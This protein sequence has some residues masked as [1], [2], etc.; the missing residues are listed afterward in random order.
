MIPASVQV[1]HRH[2][3]RAAKLL[4]DSDRR[5]HRIRGTYSIS[6][7]IGLLPTRRRSPAANGI[8]RS[9]RDSWIDEGRC[10]LIA[11][12]LLQCRQIVGQRKAIIKDAIAAAN[13]GY[14]RFAAPPRNSIG[15]RDAWS[16]VMRATNHVLR[17]ET[18]PIAYRQI[19]LRLPVIFRIESHIRHAARYFQLV[20]RR[21]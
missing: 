9:T 6:Q 15:K 11:T 3:S 18:K 7:R 1:V 8:L 17:F 16:K 10:D 19:W 21:I 2:R 13:H 14:R 5:L 12:I 4:V 20:D